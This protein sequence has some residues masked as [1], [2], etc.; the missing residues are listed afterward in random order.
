MLQSLRLGASYERKVEP[1]EQPYSTKFP[2][3]WRTELGLYRMGTFDNRTEASAVS[4]NATIFIGDRGLGNYITPSQFLSSLGFHEGRMY[5]ENS[6]VLRYLPGAQ[7]GLYWLNN[8]LRGARVLNQRDRPD[9]AQQTAQQRYRYGNPMN[10]TLHAGDIDFDYQ[11][12]QGRATLITEVS[13]MAGVTNWSV[14]TIHGYFA[15]QGS[16]E[17]AKSALAHALDT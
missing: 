11:G 10:A 5:K 16:E 3:G 9:L 1:R 12:Q 14:V 13:S 6:M 4:P 15:K 2:T 7:A 17:E 8:R